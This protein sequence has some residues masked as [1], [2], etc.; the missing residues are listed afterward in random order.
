VV[1]LLP[2][3]LLALYQ[4]PACQAV[5]AAV[6]AAV[7][8]LLFLMLCHL[9]SQP[10]RVIAAVLSVLCVFNCRCHERQHI[11]LLSS[12]HKSCSRCIRSS[13][14]TKTPALRA[15]VQAWYVTFALPVSLQARIF[16]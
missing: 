3:L 2:S 1:A 10:C 16:T 9:P 15:V 8:A 6:A 4:P 5:A 13:S 11:H 12:E 7:L 14:S